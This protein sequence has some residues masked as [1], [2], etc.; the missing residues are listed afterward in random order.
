MVRELYKKIKK[1]N[2]PSH[3]EECSNEDSFESP[4]LVEVKDMVKSLKSWSQRVVPFLA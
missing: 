4:Y 1:Y 2:L 3:L